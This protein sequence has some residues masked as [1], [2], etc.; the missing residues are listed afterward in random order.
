MLETPVF[1]TVNDSPPPLR[2]RRTDERLSLWW[3]GQAGFLLEWSGLRILIDPYLS[4]SLAQKYRGTRFPH[5]RLMEPPVE[6]GELRDIDLFFSTHGHTDH[7]D[8]R[9]I[10]PVAAANPDCLFVVP[11]SCSGLARERGVPSGRLI[12][13]EAFASMSVGE[14]EVYPIPSAHED[15]AI[16]EGGHHKFLGY[17]LRRFGICLYHSGDCCPYP[18]LPDNLAPHTIDLALLPVNGRDESRRSAGIAGNFRLEEAVRLSDAAG[19]HH[20]VGHHF[21]MFE[22]NT[23][24]VESAEA[25]LVRLAPENFL[26]ARIGVRYEFTAQ[27]NAGVSD[28]GSST[29][30][31]DGVRIGP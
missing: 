31:V 17:I 9:T 29:T 12:E 11:S 2:R 16:D 14:L 5:L 4:D 27:G 6:V 13:A 30:T 22:F 10:A 21:G 7:L 15:L 19:F 25:D 26:L 24:D 23:V 18:G 20:C 3:L 8:P 28:R 1:R